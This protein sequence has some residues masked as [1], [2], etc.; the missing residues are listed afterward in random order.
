VR[1]KKLT[2]NPQ[3]PGQ[4]G[5]ERHLGEDDREGGTGSSKVY[6]EVL[7]NCVTSRIKMRDRKVFMY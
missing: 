2:A 6:L 5:V 4:L 1:G 3:R 7:E